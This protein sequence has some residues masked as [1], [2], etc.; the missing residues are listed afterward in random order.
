MDLRNMAVKSCRTRA[1]DRKEWAANMR[2]AK[3]III[4]IIIIIII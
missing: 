1:L 3:G 4:I 2:E